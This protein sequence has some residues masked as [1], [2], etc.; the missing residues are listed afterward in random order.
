M[1]SDGPI[2]FLCAGERA[3]FLTN[4]KACHL[5]FMRALLE[6][7]SKLNSAHCIGG[8]WKDR[9]ACWTAAIEVPLHAVH[10]F[11]D[12]A[13]CYLSYHSDLQIGFDI[14]RTAKWKDVD[15]KYYTYPYEGLDLRGEVGDE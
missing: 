3:P 6:T 13:Q 9:Y 12:I 1:R 15:G 5:R 10:D 4:S 2:I 11:Q 14:H 8:N 7:R